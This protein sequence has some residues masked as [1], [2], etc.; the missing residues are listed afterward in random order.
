MGA[1]F[2][3]LSVLGLS[4]GLA[5]AAGTGLRVLLG[6]RA[7]SA[8]FDAAPPAPGLAAQLPFR[9][10]G[11]GDF[12]SSQDQGNFGEALT[13]LAMA[14][15]GW[16][17][18]NGKVGGPQGIDGIFV[19]DGAQGLEAVLIETKTGSSAYADKSMSDA[20]LLGNLDTLYVTAPDAAHEA[21]Y[22]AIAEGLKRAAPTVTKELWRH[23][24]ETGRTQTVAL[25]RDGE[26]LSRGRVLDL[27][28]LG[29]ALAASLREFDRTKQYLP[30]QE[31][32]QPQPELQP[33]PPP[34]SRPDS[35]PEPPTPD[36]RPPA[37]RRSAPAPV[38]RSAPTFA[39][40]SAPA[41][42]M[43]SA[44]IPVMKSRPDARP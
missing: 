18:V 21:V 15:R 27:R 23:A 5:A 32:A 37:P 29:E 41:P 20:K 9:A 6:R 7:G 10:L 22:A 42:V 26:R 38:M 36:A 24:L 8:R 43:R 4:A 14:A 44:P 12:A 16:R 25:G 2:A 33:A 40:R 30:R 3:V 35:P 11:H 31:P 1:A 19:R 17:V 28:I 13:T 34:D 39:L